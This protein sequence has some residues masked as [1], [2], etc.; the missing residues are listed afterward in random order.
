MHAHI[1]PSAGAAR[2]LLG[3]TPRDAPLTRPWSRQRRSNAWN[4]KLGSRC[5]RTRVGLVRNPGAR[6]ASCRGKFG[7]NMTTLENI[8]VIV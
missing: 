3:W 4:P 8:L 2:S 7:R 1:P 6:G 5:E